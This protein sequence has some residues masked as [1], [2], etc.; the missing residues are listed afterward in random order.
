MAPCKRCGRNSKIRCQRQ[1]PAKIRRNRSLRVPRKQRRKSRR[2]QTLNR[3]RIWRSR[4]TR[5]KH[6]QQPRNLL[7]GT[8]PKQR[9]RLRHRRRHPKL[10][11][12]RPRQPRNQKLKNLSQTL[13]LHLAGR[14]P[15]SATGLRLRRLPHPRPVPQHRH[16]LEQVLPHPQR[17]PR[18]RQ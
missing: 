13:N 18:H 9:P 4:Q 16:R 11:R 8:V 10:L 17:A 15:R 2:N 12:P 5:S 1:T 6:R 7:D 14:H 3:R